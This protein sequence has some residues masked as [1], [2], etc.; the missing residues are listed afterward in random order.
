MVGSAILRHLLMSGH[1]PACILTRS[2]AE[3]DLLDQAAV[4][5]F[6]DQ[7]A[8]D[9]VYLAAAKVGGIHANNTFP[10]DS[11]Y[12]NLMMEANVIDAAFRHGVRKLLFLGSSCIYPRLATQ[13]IREEALLSGTLEGTNEPY[14]IAK[15]AGLKLCESFNRQYSA[16]HG[17]DYRCVMPSNLYGPGDNYHAENSHVIPAL[18]RRFHEAKTRGALGVEVWGTGAA[19]REFMH[20]DDMAAACV[21]VMNL[22]PA[23]HA[24]VSAPMRSHLNAG[25][26]ADIAI[27]DLA[28]MVATTVGYQ[29]NLQFD[30]SRPDGVPRKLL[31]SA[32]LRSVGWEPRVQLA[33]GLVGAYRD[34]LDNESRRI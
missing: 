22:E 28:A 5:A 30:A 11:I 20:V 1:P 12:Q 15:I 2:H 23:V 4:R 3:L 18:I 24:T 10:A 32:R 27:A 19:R 13:P 34:F 9:Q 29:G 8:P 7:A 31:D 25:W 33:D 17:I 16:T 6:F 14:A 26:G 21:H